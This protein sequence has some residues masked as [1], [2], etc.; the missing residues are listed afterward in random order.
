MKLTEIEKIENKIYFI[1]GHKVMT[2]SDLAEIYQVETRVLNQAVKRNIERF[3]EDFMF[4][5]NERE[6]ETLRSQFVRNSTNTDVNSSQIVMSS[7]K[8]R[9]AK[10][11]PY[12]FTEHGAVMLASMLNSSVAVQ[13]SIQVVR[14][15]VKLREIISTH[16][17]LAAKFELLENKFDKHDKEIQVLFQA[18]RKLMKPPN[19]PRKKIGFKN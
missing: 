9:G 4:Q 5:L 10:Y 1:R 6:F 2:D 8:H 13:A 7:R 17:E 14:A 16:K 15:F 12:V 19:P 3:P 18:I 11:L